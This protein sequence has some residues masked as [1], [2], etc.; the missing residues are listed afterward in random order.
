MSV[1]QKSSLFPP[2]GFS[3]SEDVDTTPGFVL[4]EYDLDLRVLGG[5]CEGLKSPKN[6]IKHNIKKRKKAFIRLEIK[7]ERSSRTAQERSSRIYSSCLR[8]VMTSGRPDAPEV[9]ESL[10]LLH[11]E[12]SV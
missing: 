9:L 5:C 1:Y 8:C 10:D 4:T 11:D 6:G 2:T 7:K 3:L 12:D